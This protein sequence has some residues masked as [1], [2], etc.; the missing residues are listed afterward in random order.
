M[1]LTAESRIEG[2]Q[3]DERRYLR[4]EL[5]INRKFVFERPLVILGATFAA[6]VTL[7]DSRWLVTLVVPFLG[8]LLFNLWFTYNR[9]LS[10]ARI[11]AYLQLVHEA[12]PALEWE[13]WENSLRKYRTWLHEH[14][15]EAK[16]LLEDAT[17]KHACDGMNYYPWIYAFHLIL[18][19]VVVLLLIIKSMSTMV[20]TW[21][22]DIVVAV[23][24]GLGFCSLSAAAFMGI[25]FLF[26]PRNV[27]GRIEQNRQI[28]LN[29]YSIHGP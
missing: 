18:G 12:S 10:S 11:V 20:H 4:E 22:L 25:A 3:A 1:T 6:A 16:E 28:W 15:K 29:T 8:I 23:L 21:Y 7:A 17:A 14:R 9:L 24:A 2:I 13:G 27:I 19:V 26:R 5:N